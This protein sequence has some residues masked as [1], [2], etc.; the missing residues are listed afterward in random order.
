MLILE[1]G[2]CILKNKKLNPSCEKPASLAVRM[3]C[4]AE[5]GAVVSIVL[6]LP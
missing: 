5:P 4:C 1:K 2:Y 3:Q 6:G